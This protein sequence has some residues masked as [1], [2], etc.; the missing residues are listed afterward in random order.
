M[1]TFQFHQK[2]YL[3]SWQQ[4][5]HHIYKSLPE[6][7]SKWGKTQAMIPMVAPV[8]RPRQEPCKVWWGYTSWPESRLIWW[9]IWKY[10]KSIPTIFATKQYSI[11]M[12]LNFM[13]IPR[14][15]MK[16]HIPEKTLK[17]L[18]YQ[19][20]GQPHPLQEFV[21]W[22]NTGVTR[23]SNWRTCWPH[24]STDVYL[25]KTGAF[26]AKMACKVIDSRLQQGDDSQ[27]KI[28]ERSRCCIPLLH[29][30]KD[31]PRVCITILFILKKR[32][33][34]AILIWIYRNA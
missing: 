23:K 13:Y 10:L 28:E 31:K 11:A 27:P 32:D 34:K 20:F 26:D 15:I 2:V 6:W 12:I 25:A 7:I 19:R 3:R 18:T 30:S 17:L 9:S 14:C 16:K 33:A 29:F 24:G 1:C 5:G 21:W 4:K 22:A 8:S